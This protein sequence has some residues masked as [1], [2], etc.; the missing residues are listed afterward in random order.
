MSSSDVHACPADG[1]F[2]ENSPQCPCEPEQISDSE[3]RHRSLVEVTTEP[4][5]ARRGLADVGRV[6]AAMKGWP[7]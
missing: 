2:H 3:W 7:L 5:F 1:S 4:G 6:V